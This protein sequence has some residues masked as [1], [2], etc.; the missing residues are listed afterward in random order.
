[1]KPQ[2]I[3]WLILIAT[4]LLGALAPR[5][6]RAEDA[7]TRYGVTPQSLQSDFFDGYGQDGY[8]PARLTGYRSG[9]SVRYF[10]RWVKAGGPAWAGFFG[11]TG[12]D[13]HNRFVQR[14][15]AGFRPTDVSGYNTPD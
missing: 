2:N 6:V 4:M 14:R 15:D 3:R 12:D 10:T 7:I 11:V 13:Y 9:S 1:M 5:G 8:R